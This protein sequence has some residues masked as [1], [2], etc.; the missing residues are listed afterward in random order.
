VSDV[1]TIGDSE[2]ALTAC[3]PSDAW[4]KTQYDDSPA[5]YCEGAVDYSN[6][7]PASM[8]MMRYALTCGKSN[9]TSAQMRSYINQTYGNAT[10]TCGG[11]TPAEWNKTFDNANADGT[12]F[13][14]DT[15]PTMAT[16]NHCV[17]SG[18]S[19][20]YSAT[21]LANDMAS[22][23]VTVAILAGSAAN[24][25]TG[26]CGWNETGGHALFVS[27]WNGSTFTVYDPDSHKDSQG[28]F[29]R[30]GSSKP[31]SYKAQWTKTDVTQ[32]SGGFSSANSGQ[33][34]AL[35]AKRS[36]TPGDTITTGCT[37]SG[38]KTC[39]ADFTWSAC[40]ATR[41][42]RTAPEPIRLW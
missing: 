21:D 42:V 32:W 9:K 26:P 38:A 3:S 7:G 34:C 10:S 24:G 36:C 8:A 1:E 16:T 31:G 2:E 30:C 40:R 41:I 20:N 13:A 12:W 23:A 18:T 39:Q 5:G 11:T 37:G 6:C 4:W 14:D 27:D 19:A 17:G 22:G 15:Y 25:Q 28:N 35:T 29:V 33:L